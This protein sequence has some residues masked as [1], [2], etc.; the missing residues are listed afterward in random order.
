[1]LCPH[2]QSEIAEAVVL[3]EAGRIAVGR[4][5]AHRGQA[6]KTFACRWCGAA[7]RGRD[8]LDKH[9]RNCSQRLSGDLAE[10]T[11]ADLAALGWMPSDAA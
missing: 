3:S 11:D 4:R 7:I 9:E 5:K 10:F 1:M 6:P 2:C 8:S